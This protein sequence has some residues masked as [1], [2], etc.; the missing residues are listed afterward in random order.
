MTKSVP[1]GCPTSSW[2]HNS[3][4]IFIKCSFSRNKHVSRVPF[5]YRCRKSP[6]LLLHNLMKRKYVP[7][8]YIHDQT[9]KYFVPKS[10]RL[11][12]K[13][14]HTIWMVSR[15]PVLIAVNKDKG[16]GHFCF[17][18]IHTENFIS[19]RNFSISHS[20]KQYKAIQILHRKHF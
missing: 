19:R 2:C 17:L 7:V 18:L 9:S 13:Q 20:L 12:N 3:F 11:T 15:F 14:N 8:L 16:S 4:Q 5:I 10:Y 1:R 6:A